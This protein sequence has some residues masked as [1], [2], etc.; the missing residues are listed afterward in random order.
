MADQEEQVRVTRTM[1]IDSIFSNFPHKAQ[2]LAQELSN[3]G[4]Q[5]AGCHAATWETLEAG[6]MGHGMSSERVDELVERLNALLGEESDPNT[7]RLTT[8]AAEKYRE[9]L[10]SEGKDGWGLRFSEVPAGCNGFEYL[11]DYSESSHPTDDVIITSNGIDIH[12]KRTEL[13][14]LLGSEI[15]WVEALMGGGF[16]VTNPNVKSSCGCGTSHGY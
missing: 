5:C 11:L 1:T 12:I 9:I 10:K 8:H 13:P 2:R 7:V 4:L 15:D 3:W 16:K 14:R 6:C